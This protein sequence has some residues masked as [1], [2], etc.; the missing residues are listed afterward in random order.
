MYVCVNS[1]NVYVYM[2]YGLFWFV[3]VC[4]FL[5]GCG[6]TRHRVGFLSS[7]EEGTATYQRAERDSVRAEE[8]YS[9]LA[10]ADEH[11]DGYVRELRWDSAG[12]LRGV[13]EEWRNVGRK[14]VANGERRAGAV[15]VRSVD[16]SVRM[17][18]QRD[19]VAWVKEQEVQDVGGYEGFKGLWQIVGLGVMGIGVLMILTGKRL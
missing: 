9:L 16:D 5:L 11:V 14:V 1:F 6:S 2:R 19:S 13:R 3:F 8:A 12:Q 17:T 18:V 7:V 10:R 15:S 4:L